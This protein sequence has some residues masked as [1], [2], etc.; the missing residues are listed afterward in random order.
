M[1]PSHASDHRE[2]GREALT[3][4]MQAGLLISEKGQEIQ[5]SSPHHPS[6]QGHCQAPPSEQPRLP[7]G[8]IGLLG[9][10]GDEFSG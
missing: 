1:A 8:R 3:G 4:G 2:G 10:G 7:S 5:T 6:A 9:V